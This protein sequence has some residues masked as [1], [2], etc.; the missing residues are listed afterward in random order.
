MDSA[1]VDFTYFEFGTIT[2]AVFPI[3][4]KAF[5]DGTDITAAMQEADKVMNEELTKAWALLK[6]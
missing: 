4:A 6:S 5:S 1:A 3:I 2:N